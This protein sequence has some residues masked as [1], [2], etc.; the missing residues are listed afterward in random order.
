MKEKTADWKIDWGAEVR[1]FS[2][3]E[4]ASSSNSRL[5]C[6][7]QV[8]SAAASQSQFLAAAQDSA[9]HLAQL[10]YGLSPARPINNNKGSATEQKDGLPAQ[11]SACVCKIWKEDGG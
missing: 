10:I 4:R 8:G 1:K 6:W 9:G 5:S 3:A 2:L 11:P 7:V